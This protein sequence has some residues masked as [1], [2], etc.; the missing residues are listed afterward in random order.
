MYSNKAAFSDSKGWLLYPGS[1]LKWEDFGYG[2]EFAKTKPKK[3]K[4]LISCAY[5]DL[6][7]VEINKPTKGKN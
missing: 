4:K 1:L 7:C 3:R 5:D 2:T 6:V